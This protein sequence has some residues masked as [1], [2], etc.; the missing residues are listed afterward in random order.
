MRRADTK[1][2]VIDASVAL[3]AGSSEIPKMPSKLCRDFLHAVLRGGHSVAFT[4][5]I[6]TE[7]NDHAARFAR[8]WKVQMM[9]RK[10]VILLV[11]AA[12][13]GLERRALATTTLQS[14]KEAIQKDLHLIYAALEADRLIISLDQKIRMLFT[15]AKVTVAELTEIGW[16]NPDQ[17]TIDVIQWLENGADL[18]D[19]KL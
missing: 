10:R 11:G 15:A 9:G 3:K 1:C 8:S 12:I 17:D 7:W 19:V 5:K 4:D 13:P 6:K 14:A 16:V 18:N 2:L